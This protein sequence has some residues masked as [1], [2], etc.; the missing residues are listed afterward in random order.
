VKSA[1]RKRVPAE[2]AF[3]RTASCACGLW[4]PN[5]WHVHSAFLMAAQAEAG[6]PRDVSSA[7]EA[8]VHMS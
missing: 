2:H 7:V 6:D 5:E 1:C 4:L 3:G 8:I